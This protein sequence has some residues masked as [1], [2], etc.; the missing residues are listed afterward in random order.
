LS[1][2]K[3]NFAKPTKMR[4]TL[5]AGSLQVYAIKN[6][7]AIQMGAHV[8]YQTDGVAPERMVGQPQFM[9]IWKKTV[10]GWKIVKIVSYDH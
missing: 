8:F 10:H 4:R 2:L 3:I 6:F 1:D 7:G 5:L 9:H